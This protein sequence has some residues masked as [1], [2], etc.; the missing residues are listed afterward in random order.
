MIWS[1]STFDRRS[2][3]PIPVWV[4]NASMTSP[5]TIRGDGQV[6]R[7]RQGSPHRGGGGDGGRH[8][9]GASALALSALE[10][11]VGGR[12]TAFPRSELIGIHAEAHRATGLPP[13]RARRDE[14]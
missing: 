5:L 14:D 1:V 3:T 12:R 11:S 10:I 8:Q 6:G 9:M 13:L 7:G 4:W 2:G